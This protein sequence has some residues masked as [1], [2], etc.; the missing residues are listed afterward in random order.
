MHGAISLTG[1]PLYSAECG[2]ACCYICNPI[3]VKPGP[4]VEGT[5]AF[6]ECERDRDKRVPDE[7]LV[8]ASAVGDGVV[9]GE[10]NRGIPDLGA[11]QEADLWVGGWLGGWAVGRAGWAGGMGGMGILERSE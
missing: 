1:T 9:G 3:P 11:E 5:Y 2:E 4:G 8:V 10:V 6:V 7:R